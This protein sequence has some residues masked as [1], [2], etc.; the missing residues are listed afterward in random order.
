MVAEQPP[1]TFAEVTEKLMEQPRPPP[2]APALNADEWIGKTWR[3]WL[4]CTGC[5]RVRPPPRREP[6]VP[7]GGH[8]TFNHVESGHAPALPP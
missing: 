6:P 5:G 7:M 3:K 8:E 4:A 2:P 1:Q